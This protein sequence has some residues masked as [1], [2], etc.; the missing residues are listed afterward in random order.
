MAAKHAVQELEEATAAGKLAPFS[1]TTKRNVYQFAKLCVKQAERIA[2]L[3][4]T[5]EVLEEEEELYSV[6]VKT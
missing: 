2:R 6:V 1:E 5:I 3:E 4:Q